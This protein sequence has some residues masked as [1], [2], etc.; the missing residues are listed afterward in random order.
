MS[1]G[2]TSNSGESVA[3][4]RPESDDYDLLTFGE[5]AARLS[6]ELDAAAVELERVRQNPRTDPGTIRGLEKRIQLLRASKD[7]YRQEEQTNEAYAR[8]FG[9]LVTPSADRRPRWG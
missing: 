4:Q 1:S 8:R 9:S 5:V 2:D 6:E 7:R 3:D